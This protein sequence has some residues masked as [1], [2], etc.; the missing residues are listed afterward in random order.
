MEEHWIVTAIKADMKLE[1]MFF[2]SFVCLF[3]VMPREFQL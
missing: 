3:L 2:Y 1:I